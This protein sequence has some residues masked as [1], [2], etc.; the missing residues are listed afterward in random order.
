MHYY[1]AAGAIQS[2]HLIRSGSIAKSSGPP[3][4][5]DSGRSKTGS[6]EVLLMVLQAGSFGVVIKKITK[7]GADRCKTLEE[8][9]S[10]RRHA[11]WLLI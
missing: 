3:R 5:G 10:P 9:C 7:Q 4:H 2:C 6:E 8:Y 1:P 11:R